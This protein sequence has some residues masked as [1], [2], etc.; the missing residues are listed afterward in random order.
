MDSRQMASVMQQMA[1]T[2]NVPIMV[3]FGNINRSDIKGISGNDIKAAVLSNTIRQLSPSVIEEQIMTLETQRNK[4]TGVTRQEYAET[5]VRFT[6]Q[7]ANTLYVQA[8]AVNY[9]FDRKFER[10]LILYGTVRKGQ[11]MQDMSNPMGGLTNMM[12]GG[13]QINQIAPGQNPFQGLM[14]H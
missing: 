6:S 3:N 10:K 5:V 13:G 8:A 12:Q 7:S 14:P 9:T 11:V 4:K 2:M 1:N